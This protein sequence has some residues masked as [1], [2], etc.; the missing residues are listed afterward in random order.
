MRHAW[1][2]LLA[3][4]CGSSGG[5]GEPQ[6]GTASAQYGTTT[7]AMTVGAAILDPN[8][9][10]NMIVELGN[11]NVSCGVDLDNE[12]PPSGLY[13]YFSVSK[14]TPGTDANAT[15]TVISS[16]GNNIDADTSNGTV[17]VDAI[18]TRVTGSVTFSSSTQTV[19]TITATG[20]FDVKK[21]F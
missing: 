9:A 16:S 13:V 4:G 20:T 14:T 2:L 10:G 7:H 19:S 11:D 12:F 15:V 6:H 21:C 5:G 1:L 3:I 17:T 18:D 8:V